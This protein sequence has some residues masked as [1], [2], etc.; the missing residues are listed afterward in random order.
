MFDPLL[1]V[2]IMPQVKVATPIQFRSQFIDGSTVKE[3][4]AMNAAVDHLGDQR[5][6]NHLGERKARIM[7]NDAIQRDVLGDRRCPTRLPIFV[8]T[9]GD[10]STTRQIRCLRFKVGFVAA[11]MRGCHQ[12]FDVDVNARRPCG[13]VSLPSRTA[14]TAVKRLAS[15]PMGLASMRLGRLTEGFYDTAVAIGNSTID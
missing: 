13:V 9:R 1:V 6:E 4:P 14:R 15:R 11:V 3:I 12:S 8:I 7:V 10:R 5:L 2:R